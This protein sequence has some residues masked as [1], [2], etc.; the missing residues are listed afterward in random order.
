M[1]K[2]EGLEAIIFDLDDT[3]YPERDYVISGFRNISFHIGEEYGLE[4]HAVFKELMLAFDG[5][6]RGNNFNKYLE[7]KGI[8]YSEDDIKKMVAIYRS[9]EPDISLPEESKYLLLHLKKQGYRL[10]L[11]TDGFYN[12]QANKVK[13]LKLDKIFKVMVFTDKYGIGYWKPNPA[14]FIEIAELLSVEACQC[15]YI[16]DNPVKDFKGAKESGMLTIQTNHWST[17]SASLLER[18]YLP[19]IIVDNLMMIPDV[20]EG[21]L[22]NG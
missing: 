18:E 17:K 9:H 5:G 10:G 1:Q 21:I 3:L 20:L 4:I 19:D 12:A 13:K 6:V 16:G 11:L 8:D 14:P 15:V 2:K 22:A 7:C